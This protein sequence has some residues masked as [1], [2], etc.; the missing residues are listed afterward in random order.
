MA[1]F[2]N[3]PLPASVSAPAII[4]PAIRFSTDGGYELRRSKH[5]RPR[6]RYTLDYLGK[7]AENLHYLR[8]FIAE[9]RLG[10]TPFAFIHPTALD[11]V[12]ITNTTPVILTYFHGLNTGQMV[13]VSASTNTSLVALGW[14]VTRISN[15]QLSLNGSTAGGAGTATVQVYLPQAVLTFADDTW[16]S[17]TKLI[18]PE[19]VGAGAFSWQLT[20][21]EIF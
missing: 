18:G 9:V 16:T 20:I 6:R 3:F 7:P 21:E 5:S 13:W 17:P 14:V 10:V 2:P 19:R 4:D 8:D 11:V 12:T 1:F 15:S